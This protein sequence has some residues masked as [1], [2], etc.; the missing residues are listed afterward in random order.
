MATRI[1]KVDALEQY[2]DDYSKY[3]IYIIRTRVLPSYIDGLKLLFHACVVAEIQRDVNIRIR[4][5]E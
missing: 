2:I 5:K 3:G 4:R 1:I